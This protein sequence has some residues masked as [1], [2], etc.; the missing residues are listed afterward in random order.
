MSD[1]ASTSTQP[2]DAN[3]KMRFLS[4]NLR[5]A[6][7]QEERHTD[8]WNNWRF[9]REAVIDLIKKANPDVLALQEDSDEQL[10]AIQDALK[11]SHTAYCDPAFYQADN[12]YV[13]IF[14]RNSIKVSGSGA[15]WISGDG[16]TQS[17]IDG[18]ICF[19]HATHASLQLSGV[20][21]LI[22]NVHLDHR[23]DRA[24]KRKETEVF[25]DLLS[26][27]SG[28]PPTRTIV[29]GDFNSTPNREPHFLLEQYGLHDSARLQG[30]DE[31]TCI[32][33]AK[34]PASERIDYVWMSD[35]LKGKVADY[36]VISGSYRRQDGSPGHASDHSAVFAQFDI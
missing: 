35:D 33:W 6:G 23:D 25:I 10:K 24:V 20:S 27:M 12:A 21:L 18:S 11:E 15:F 14:I 30:D 34:N 36:K 9:R 8:I 2:R 29:L 5:N 1:A 4:Y 16:K 3:V 19:R 31:A 17:K 13:A 7:I 32:H 22:V 26:T 28:K